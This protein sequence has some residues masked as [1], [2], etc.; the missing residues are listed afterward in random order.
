MKNSHLDIAFAGVTVVIATGVFRFIAVPFGL[1]IYVVSG[2]LLLLNL[3]YVVLRIRA[4]RFKKKQI[5]P[6]VILLLVWP[7]ISVLYS[8][9][10]D[11]RAAL[12]SLNTF[13]TFA[14]VSILIQRGQIAI[15]K[16]ALSASLVLTYIGTILNLLRPDMF[17]EVARLADAYVLTMGRPGGFHLQPNDLAIN[18]VLLFAGKLALDRGDRPIENAI[19][20]GIVVLIVLLTGSRTGLVTV[21]IVLMIDVIGRLTKGAAQ[22]RVAKSSL[23]F[24]TSLA[25]MSVAVFFIAKSVLVFLESKLDMV[26][27]GLVD[28]LDAFLS[29]QLSYDSVG[30]QTQSISHRFDAQLN[31]IRLIAEMPITGRGIGSE[32]VYLATGKI[33]LS[34]HSSF[35]SM[36]F[37][38]G[39]PYAVL[40]TLALVSFIF[41]FRQS[42]NG[43]RMKRSDYLSFAVLA[44][45]LFFYSGALVSSVP[46]VILVAMAVTSMARASAE[47]AVQNK[48]SCKFALGQG[49]HAFSTG[50]TR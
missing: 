33:P 48:M 18:V 20:A 14:G 26:P 47:T 42:S 28:R 10:S 11:L 29:F 38:Y 7:Q 23:K 31:Y 37:E 35:L 45:V 27:G 34:S 19:S 12:L 3:S 43:V 32:Q 49:P 4:F 17:A 22:V 8:V 40:F 13:L 15:L 1:P 2:I 5:L 6:W 16:R 41:L 36:A 46:F 21:G 24:L 39:I 44:L 9:G 25:L 50:S 30:I